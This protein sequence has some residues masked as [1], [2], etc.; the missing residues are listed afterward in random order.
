MV[1]GYSGWMC[2]CPAPL[3]LKK[4]VA[5]MSKEEFAE[6]LADLAKTRNF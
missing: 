2:C 5:E 1:A 6:A 3:R 4:G